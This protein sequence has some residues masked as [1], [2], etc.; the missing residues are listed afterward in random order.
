MLPISGLRVAK[1]VA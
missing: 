1:Q